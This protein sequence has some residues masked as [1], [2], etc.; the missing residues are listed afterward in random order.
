MQSRV[1]P[2]P[3]ECHLYILLSLPPV[4]KAGKKRGIVKAIWLARFGLLF[5]LDLYA[6]L[7]KHFL[8]F[9]IYTQLWSLDPRAIS[10]LKAVLLVD[11]QGNLYTLEANW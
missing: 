5:F 3:H 11:E 7:H 8:E 4:P 9:L 2:I 10:F 1:W 6:K